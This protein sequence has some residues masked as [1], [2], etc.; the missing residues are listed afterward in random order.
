MKRI[1]LPNIPGHVVMVNDDQAESHEQMIKARYAVVVREAKSRGWDPD[2]LTFEQIFA[3][4]DLD[5]WK[6]AGP[7]GDR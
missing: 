6:N 4:R 2:N 5:E 3:I 7:A 1:E